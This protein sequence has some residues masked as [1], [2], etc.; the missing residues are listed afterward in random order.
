MD[1][2]RR[3]RVVVIAGSVTVTAGLAWLAFLL[4]AW[5]FGTRNYVQHEQRLR[6]MVGKKPSLDQVTR[7][8]ADEGAPLVAAPASE[9]ERERLARERGGAR[10][11]EIMEKGRRFP[12]VRVFRADSMLYFLYFDG[13]GTLRD[14]V[15]VTK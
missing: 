12:L 7:G 13:N 11:A 8:L 6:N 14:Y 4:G 9:A 2:D 15:L 3:Q 10:A 5:G 1:P